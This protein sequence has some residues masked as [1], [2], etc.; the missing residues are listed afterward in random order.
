MKRLIL[1]LFLLAAAACEQP[2][3]AVSGNWK[4]CPEPRSVTLAEE[5]FVLDRGVCI[6]ADESLRPQAVLLQQW[7]QEYTGITPRLG[8]VA[9]LQW[10]NPETRDFEAFLP[11]LY[12]MEEIYTARGWNWNEVK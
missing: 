12:K 10:A 9:E 8:A 7:L 3:Q 2:R 11:R 5:S 1:L 4:L 6:R